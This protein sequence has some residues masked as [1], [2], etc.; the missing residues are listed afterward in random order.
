MKLPISSNVA[1]IAC[2]TD[3]FNAICSACLGASTDCGPI[4]SADSAPARWLDAT[5]DSA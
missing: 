5:C 1:L 4:S 2:G 3:T